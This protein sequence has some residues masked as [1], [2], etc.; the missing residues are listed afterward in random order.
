MPIPHSFTYFV[1]AQ[2]QH[3]AGWHLSVVADPSRTLLIHSLTEYSAMSQLKMGLPRAPLECP[4]V[5]ML[6]RLW[7]ELRKRLSIEG[8]G[9]HDMCTTPHS[10]WYIGGRYLVPFHS[11]HCRLEADAFPPLSSLAWCWELPV[12]GMDTY[13][14]PL[15]SQLSFTCTIGHVVHHKYNLLF[16]IHTRLLYLHRWVCPCLYFSWLFYNF[17]SPTFAPIHMLVILFFHL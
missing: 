8:L 6:R 13:Q 1:A 10:G 16:Y 5:H 17:L 14:A 2:L 7:K 9:R 4:T 12:V 3:L 11:R 15:P